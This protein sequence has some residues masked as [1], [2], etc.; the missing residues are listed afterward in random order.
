MDYLDKNKAAESLAAI[1]SMM[2]ST[3]GDMHMTAY[4]FFAAGILWVIEGVFEISLGFLKNYLWTTAGD[5]H[6]VLALLRISRIAEWIIIAVLLLAYFRCRKTQK[7]LGCGLGK[8]LL[9]VWFM[10]LIAVPLCITVLYIFKYDTEEMWIYGVGLV[11]PVVVALATYTTGRLIQSE[12]IVGASAIY[13][14]VLFLSQLLPLEFRTEWKGGESVLLLSGEFVE[15]IL[16]GLLLLLLNRVLKKDRDK[17]V[18]AD[19]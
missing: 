19:V 6:S 15:R 7:D 12:K 17:G 11:R 8:Q 2:D 9:D 18:K 1:R 16:P 10:A 5:T 14:V 4:W 3:A 13:A